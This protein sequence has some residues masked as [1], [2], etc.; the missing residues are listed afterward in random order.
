RALAL[1]LLLAALAGCSGGRAG[2][3]GKVSYDG[4]PVDGGTI[5]FIPEGEGG[6]IKV[7]G[8][9]VGGEYNL[10]ADRGPKPGKYNVQILGKQKNPTAKSAAPD[11]VSADQTIQ[12][13]PPK[14]N[15]QTT[16]TRDVK[17]GSNELSFELTK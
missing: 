6:G 8:D 12:V 16:L 17:S 2:A 1:P 7:G 5:V 9:I 15:T 14:Y 10:P 4:K 13:I 11:L 3:S